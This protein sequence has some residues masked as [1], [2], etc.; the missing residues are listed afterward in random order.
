MH[1][2][3]DENGLP[4]AFELT[5]ANVDDREG[6]EE[7]S[8]RAGLALLLGDKGYIGVKLSN[9]TLIALDRNNA[10]NPVH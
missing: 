9:A 10:K 7:L 5:G 3:V 2:V 1:L 4:V 8:I 6:A